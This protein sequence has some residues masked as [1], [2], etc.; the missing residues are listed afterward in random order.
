[1]PS[2][3]ALGLCK[4]EGWSWEAL[5]PPHPSYLKLQVVADTYILLPQQTGPWEAGDSLSCTILPQFDAEASG[6]GQSL[7]LD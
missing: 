7:A 3:Y 5:T 1:M 6:S 2:V 4:T